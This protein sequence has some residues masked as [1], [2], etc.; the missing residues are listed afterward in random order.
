VKQPLVL[1][2][3]VFNTIWMDLSEHGEKRLLLRLSPDVARANMM[4]LPSSPPGVQVSGSC[5]EDKKNVVY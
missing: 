5:C 3:F 1:R 4:K 2:A